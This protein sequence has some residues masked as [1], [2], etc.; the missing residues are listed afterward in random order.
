MDLGVSVFYHDREGPKFLEPWPKVLRTL[1]QG[2]KN[3]AKTQGW[4]KQSFPACDN[5]PNACSVV[6]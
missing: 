2:S 1:E 6:C 3:L 5:S 4:K